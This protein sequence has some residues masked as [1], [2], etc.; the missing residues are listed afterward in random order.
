MGW[1]RET[2]SNLFFSLGLL[3]ALKQWI[4]NNGKTLL[5]NTD[6]EEKEQTELKIKRHSGFAF[7]VNFCGYFSF[8]F[9]LYFFASISVDKREDGIS[10][11]HDFSNIIA[12]DLC[13]WGT[14]RK[15]YNSY[16]KASSHFDLNTFSQKNVFKYQDNV[17]ALQHPVMTFLLPS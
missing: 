5:A 1:Q 3:S 10:V 4:L 8:P 13:E 6:K 17:S 15:K 7:Y 14:S 16:F 12:L 11:F 9:L 2:Q